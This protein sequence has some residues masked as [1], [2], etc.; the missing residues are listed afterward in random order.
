LVER[1]QPVPRIDDEQNQVG[2]IDG[3]LD[4]LFDVFGE[5]VDIR[6]ADA[7]GIAELEIPLAMLHQVREA[8][9]RDA[10]HVIHDG[11]PPLGHPIEEAGLPD[12]GPADDN[13]L[14]NAHKPFIIV[15]AAG[16][17]PA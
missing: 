17:C 5:I 2:R 12:V 14:G 15:A 8:I 6:D 13:Y 11:E 1:R 7:A 4:L 16:G 10:G 9:A 3:Q